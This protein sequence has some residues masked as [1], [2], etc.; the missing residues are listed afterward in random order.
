MFKITWIPAILWAGFIL[1]LCGFPG[2][3]IPHFKWAD[4]LSLDKALHIAIFAVQT[5]LLVAPLL[6][7][8]VRKPYLM[9]ALL[10]TLFGG[11]VE[12]LQTYVFIN[13]FGDVTDF[14]ADALGA[15]MVMYWFNY[16][17]KT[18]V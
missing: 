4:M 7:A 8:A 3:E 10:S 11:I 5:Y 12:L 15:F 9:S 16:K 14:L 1:V 6:K 2:N 18:D 13:R 17:S